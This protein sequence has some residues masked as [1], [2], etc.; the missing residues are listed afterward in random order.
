MTGDE[1]VHQI[2]ETRPDAKVICMT[3]SSED[4]SLSDNPCWRNLSL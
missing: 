2:R 4:V 1:A 3:S